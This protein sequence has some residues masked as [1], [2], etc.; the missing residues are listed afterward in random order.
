MQGT[1]VE[2]LVEC[3]PEVP[4]EP[5]FVLETVDL[6][7]GEN[8]YQRTVSS[9]SRMDVVDSQSKLTVGLTAWLAP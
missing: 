4:E 3:V 9:C 8:S 7:R 2:L 5:G 6:L 1:Y